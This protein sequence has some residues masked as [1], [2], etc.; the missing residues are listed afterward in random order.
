MADQLLK[1]WAKNTVLDPVKQN[2]QRREIREEEWLQGLGRLFGFTAQH[3][4]T[5]F[6]LLSHHSAPSDICPY[7]FPSGGVLTSEMLHM[8]GQTI[9]EADQPY[10]FAEYGATLTDMTADN[11][12][13]FIWI[14]RNH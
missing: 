14:V 8:N 13:G 11:L 2:A 3:V 6:N 7:V 10:L 9:T 4:N 1:V 12:T 5:L